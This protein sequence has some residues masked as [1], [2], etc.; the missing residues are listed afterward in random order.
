MQKYQ[1]KSIMGTSKEQC[2]LDCDQEA[3]VILEGP[4]IRIPACK[5]CVVL[6][7]VDPLGVNPR[8]EDT[9]EKGV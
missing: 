9:E 8:K 2:Q 1:I 7:V 6:C 4:K 5:R 3:E